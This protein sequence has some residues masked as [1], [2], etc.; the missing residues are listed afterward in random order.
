MTAPILVRPALLLV[1]FMELAIYLAIILV[2]FLVFLSIFY[3]GSFLVRNLSYRFV[4]VGLL[5]YGFV[6]NFLGV[7]AGNHDSS[8]NR[9]VV[10]VVRLVSAYLTLIIS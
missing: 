7:L 2:H 4:E 8:L 6:P 10:G 1:F 3:F 5:V 9:A